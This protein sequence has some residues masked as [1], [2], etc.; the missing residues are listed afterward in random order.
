MIRINVILISLFV[1]LSHLSASEAFVQENDT[2]QELSKKEAR[3]LKRQ[4]KN[5]RV[6]I[7]G[8]PGYTPDFGLLIGGSALM[9]FKTNKE[10]SLIQR[11]VVPVG[12]AL[13][14]EGG[15]NLISRP[16]FFFNEDKFR[17][18]GQ[19]IVKNTL[20]NYYGIGY[21]TNK[22]I[23]RGEETTQYRAS[24]WQI[25]PIF[26]FRLG[27]SNFFTGPL[28]D[29]SRDYMKNPS[30]GVQSDPDYIAQGGTEDGYISL[31]TGV[32]VALSY[33]TRDIP[34]NAYS[35]LMFE[36]KGSFFSSALGGDS[37]YGVASVEY[38]QY[39]LLKFLG[40]RRS[41]A[42][43]AQSKNSFGEVPITRMQMVGSPFDLR[44]YY[45]GQY[46]D[47]ST[48][49]AIAEYRHMFNSDK[50]NFWGRMHNRL[51]F[52]AW[53]GF[54]MMGPDIGHIEA[55]LPNF[56][57]GLRIEVQPRMNFRIDVGHSPNDGHTLVY[58]NMTEAF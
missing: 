38:R 14:F 41:L 6:S 51:G 33:D 44:G 29:L 31:N 15:F 58:F 17:I 24:N 49:F 39:T 27:E 25:N 34:A 5:F 47:K 45:L 52:A 4:S 7:L 43:T 20:D 56:G 13:M 37:D 2:T 42:W 10:D 30:V 48:H 40:K 16:Q 19:V 32:G 54:G 50:E 26:L 1:L 22:E 8:G 3:K 21:D 57:A 53:G 23:E 36:F 12:F 55:V 9:T 46:R 11:S 35:G 18:F 28:M